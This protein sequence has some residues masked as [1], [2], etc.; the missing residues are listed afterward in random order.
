MTKYYLDIDEELA[1]RLKQ[2]AEQDIIEVLRELAEN[3]TSADELGGYTDVKDIRSDE[4][5]T[6]A[7]RKR[8]E[9]LWQRRMGR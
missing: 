2:V 4:S 3:E 8:M 7:E 6:P 1:E 5:L 9:I